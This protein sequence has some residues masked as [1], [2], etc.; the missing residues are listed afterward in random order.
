VVE[1]GLKVRKRESRRR[2]EKKRYKSDRENG[3]G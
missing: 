3:E 2:M 1:K